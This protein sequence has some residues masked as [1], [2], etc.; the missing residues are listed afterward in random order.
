MSGFSSSQKSIE[1]SM[2]ELDLGHIDLLMVE[3]EEIEEKLND[4]IENQTL[5][6][7]SWGALEE[8]YMLQ[9]ARAIGVANYEVS[10][11]IMLMDDCVEKPH[12]N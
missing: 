9:N 5:R 8:A 12:F 1:K 2:G 4:D 11:L 3:F 7:D 10:H 6:S